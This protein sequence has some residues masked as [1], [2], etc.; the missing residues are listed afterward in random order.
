MLLAQCL[1]TPF[2]L[3]LHN[4]FGDKLSIAIK[5]ESIIKEENLW[6]GYNPRTEEF[7]DMYEAGIIDPAKVTRLALENAASVAGTMLTTEAV[8]SNIE[9]EDSNG[10]V[11]PEMLFG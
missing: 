2:K 10:E 9:E 8:I 1:N 3:I 7:V 5:Q 11:N 4:A 6:F